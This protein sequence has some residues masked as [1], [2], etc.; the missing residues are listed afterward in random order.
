MGFKVAIVG[1]TGLVGEKILTVLDERDFPVDKVFL[2]ATGMGKTDEYFK[3]EKIEVIPFEGT[4]FPETDVAFFSAGTDI[5]KRF[6]KDFVNKGAIV[7]DNSPAFREDE[8]IPLIIPEINPEKIKETKGIISN[9]NCS[10]IIMLLP[11]YPIY[12]RWG[13]KRIIASTYQ[14]VSG[15]GREALFDL[16]KKRIPPH[17]FPFTIEK[18]IIPHI[19]KPLESG[20][21]SEERKMESETKKILSDKKIKISATC[22]RL[23]V[24]FGHS[25]S[26]TMELKSEFTLQAI[27][28]E[29][30][31]FPGVVI[32]D[33]PKN[34]KYPFPLLV[35]N[36]D[37]VFVGRIRVDPVFKNGLSMW[38]AGDN[39]RKG[40][41]T[42][43]VQI[44]ELLLEPQM[45]TEKIKNE[46]SE[47]F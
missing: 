25:I 12:K 18:N 37:E 36:K 26:V 13:I 6:A 4:K 47:R 33:E 2:F 40:A 38:I 29:L 5:P 27:K 39:I 3:K 7:I 14:S 20:F 22:V 41:A 34:A 24:R 30:Q 31:V 45:N 28:K 46:V 17:Y 43:A 21:S 15:A 44:A 8:T 9:P 19:G 35:E 10:T 1:A 42:N 32:Y 23:P 11:I 16:D